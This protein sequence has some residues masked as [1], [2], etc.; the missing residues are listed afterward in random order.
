MY[1]NIHWAPGT[2]VNTEDTSPNRRTLALQRGFPD[3]SVLRNPP[4]NAGGVGSCQCRKIPWRKKWRPIPVSLPG[5]SHGQR[6]LMGY[7][8]RGCKELDADLVRTAKFIPEC[9]RDLHLIIWQMRNLGA[10]GV[11]AGG[12]DSLDYQ[13]INYPALLNINSSPQPNVLISF[14]N[15]F[16]E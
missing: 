5:K 13:S 11:K 10:E 14:I 4:A 12:P 7:S 16:K 15:L 1:I 8:P 3:G 9:W 6:S 2:P